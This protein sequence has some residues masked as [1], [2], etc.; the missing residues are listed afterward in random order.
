MPHNA[1]SRR[2]AAAVPLVL[3]GEFGRTVE[4][5]MPAQED[6]AVAQPAAT[7][8]RGA[9]VAGPHLKTVRGQYTKN[10]TGIVGISEGWEHAREC[11]CFWVQLGSTSRR[12]NITRLG[13]AEALRRA[14]S[15]RR[16]HL[17]KLALANAAIIAARL[18]ASARRAS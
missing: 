9:A 8:H 16:A 1:K 7:H 13:R 14:I 2:L 5:Y 15:L 10:K 17:E 12:F 3:F 11:R 6:L 4:G 18:Q